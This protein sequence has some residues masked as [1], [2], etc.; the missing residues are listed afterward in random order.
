MVVVWRR[1]RPTENVEQRIDT[2]MQAL[3][4]TLLVGDL[5]QT[6]GNSIRL[7]GAAAIDFALVELSRSFE[8]KE[9]LAEAPF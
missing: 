1:T 4:D 6:T 7:I 3:R 9:D 2:F 5:H 8:L